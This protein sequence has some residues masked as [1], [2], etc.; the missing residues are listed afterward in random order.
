[1]NE[2]TKNIKTLFF[3]YMSI[4][5]LLFFAVLQTSQEEYSR[6]LKQLSE[7]ESL[8]TSYDEW[9]IAK[10]AKDRVGDNEKVVL[11]KFVL[12]DL[13]AAFEFEHRAVEI[14][15]DDLARKF[16]GVTPRGFNFNRV[17]HEVYPPGFTIT[18]PVK[19]FMQY[20]GSPVRLGDYKKVHSNILEDLSFTSITPDFSMVRVESYKLKEQFKNQIGFI[21]TSVYS[22]EKIMEVASEPYA[23]NSGMAIRRCNMRLLKAQVSNRYVFACSTGPIILRGEKFDG[24]RIL[25]AGKTSF[26]TFRKR[27]LMDLFHIPEDRRL[28]Y[29]RAYRELSDITEAYEFLNYSDAAKIIESEKRRNPNKL[30]VFGADINISI[31]T[32]LI[33]PIL[34]ILSLYIYLHLK[35]AERRAAS[36][37]DDGDVINTPWVGIYEG[38][39]NL[40]A[41]FVQLVIFPI[42]LMALIHFKS[43]PN[44]QLILSWV[45][46]LTL[47]ATNTAN[48]KVIIDLRKSITV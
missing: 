22:G 10:L 21:D 33:F 30:T 11:S 44:E 24:A 6:A 43:E 9:A 39:I 3:S 35:E 29:E 16:E 32:R 18:R 25:V 40:F 36:K 26:N 46:F 28:P 23:E 5:V 42:T 2:I 45:F 20:I 17:P 31:L 37:Q 34:I 13:E 48:Y 41:I 14:D 15:Y 12:S 27:E 1:M 7:I 19:T 47:I 8:S 4:I 38:K